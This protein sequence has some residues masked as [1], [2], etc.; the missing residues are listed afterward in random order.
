MA[1]HLGDTINDVKADQVSYAPKQKKN[2]PKFTKFD[3]DLVERCHLSLPENIKSYL[4]DRG[5]TDDLVGQFKI[6]YGEFYDR[7]WITI[8]VKDRDGIFCFLKLRKDPSDESNDNKY[9]FY[10]TGSGAEIFG[11]ECLKDNKDM[12][13]VCEGEFDCMMLQNFGI[14]SITSTAEAGNFKKEWIE[15]LVDLEK[16]YVCFDKD[17]AGEKGVSS[18]LSNWRKICQIRL[19]TKLLSQTG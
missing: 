7:K 16:I 2:L 1:K 12:V 5:I 4:V 14:P 18:W 17:E 8:P 15:E 11:R 9:K 3:I 10:P 13:V 6:G 19:F